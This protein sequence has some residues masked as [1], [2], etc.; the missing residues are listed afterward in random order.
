MFIACLTAIPA[1][2]LLPVVYGEEFAEASV[3]LLLLLPGVFCIG[4]EMVLVQH[5]SGTGMPGAIPV[6]WVVTLAV[7]GALNFALVPVYGGRGAAI[8]STLG[9]ALI[10]ALVALRFRRETGQSFAAMLLLRGG[11][12]REIFARPS[13]NG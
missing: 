11:E 3:Q 8:A 1:S 12:L 7:C 5:F 9:Y 2:L 10:F 4:V 13:F 6:F